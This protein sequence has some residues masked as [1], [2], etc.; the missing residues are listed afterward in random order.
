MFEAHEH[1]KVN[2]IFM[3]LLPQQQQMMQIV[4]GEIQI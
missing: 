3:I 4:I 2:N 1:E